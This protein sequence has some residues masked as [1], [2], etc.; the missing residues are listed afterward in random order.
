MAVVCVS[1]PSPSQICGCGYYICTNMLLANML[2][3][4]I[5]IKNCNVH[6]SSI[7]YCKIIQ[8]FTHL[9]SKVFK[10]FSW[11]EQAKYDFPAIMDYVLTTTRSKQVSAMG[12]SMGGNVV[13]AGLTYHPQYNQRLN[14][15]IFF[16]P[17]VR[18]KYMTAKI[19][20]AGPHWRHLQVKVLLILML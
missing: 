12:L 18:F 5:S 16:A 17:S 9:V 10:C 15:A 8:Y 4:L 7:S 11:E 19:K 1:L 2:S 13:I 14:V 3:N 6:N 20:M